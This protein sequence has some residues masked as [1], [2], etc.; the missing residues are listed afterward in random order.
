MIEL[1]VI[2]SFCT[3]KSILD[4]SFSVAGMI[5]TTEVIIYNDTPYI[6]TRLNRYQKKP[7]WIIFIYCLSIKPYSID[8]LQIYQTKL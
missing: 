6:S 7:F 4:D 5:L 8:R 3:L 2:D 1:G